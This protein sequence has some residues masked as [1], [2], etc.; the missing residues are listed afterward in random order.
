LRYPWWVYPS[1]AA[2]SLL[3][4][5][6]AWW[7]HSVDT[8]SMILPGEAMPDYV[9]MEMEN[10]AMELSQSFRADS[11]GYDELAQAHAEFAAFKETGD[12]WRLFPDEDALPSEVVP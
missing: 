12:S 9:A 3:L 4:A 5:F 10:R 2:A 8:G 7:G 11:Y 6:L 1:A